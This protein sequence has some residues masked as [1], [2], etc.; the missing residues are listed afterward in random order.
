MKRNTALL[1]PGAPAGGWSRSRR[2]DV[3]HIGRRIA[4]AAALGV[5]TAGVAGLGAAPAAQADSS[6]APSNIAAYAANVQALAFQYAF[7]IPG[8]FPIPGNLME[9]D[10]PFARTSVSNGPVVNAL[11]APYY[12]G[13]ILGNFGSILSLLAPPQFPAVPNDP[14]VALANYPPSPGHGQDASFG[15][16]PPAGSPLAP[17]VFSA[18]A[19]AGS[20]GSASVTATITDLQ[21]GAPTSTSSQVVHLGPQSAASSVLGAASSGPLLDVGSIQSTNTVTSSASSITGTATT[22]LK[23]IEI[24]GILDI[25]QLN[26]NASATSDGNKGSPSGAL[27]VVDATVEGQPAYID[28]QGVHISGNGVAPGGITPQ[29][30]QTALNTTFAQDGISLRLADPQMSSNAAEGTANSGGLVVTISHQFAVPYVPG[31]PSI[32]V[33]FQVPPSTTCGANAPGLGNQ[34]LPAGTYTAQT[35]ITLGSATSDV[36]ATVQPNLGAIGG[37]SLSGVTGGGGGL[38]LGTGSL[39]GTS[40]LGS[41]SFPGT[42]GTPGT[43]GIPGSEALAAGASSRFPLGIPAPLGW[44]IVGLIL[45]LIMAYPMLL[46]VRWQFLSGR[47]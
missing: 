47:R 2:S 35:S 26:S 37:G 15:G 17:N 3:L 29:E 22:V 5:C 31:S 46:T 32:P 14:A 21:A 16:N 12:P 11:G 8:L 41:T 24:A 27:H 6:S 1:N 19:H 10:V 39:G 18:K 25:N 42:A 44:L 38:G 43:A 40:A 30:A 7:S 20:D 36:Q 45:C 34:D 23:A 28:N 13:D 4:A 9:D 33:C